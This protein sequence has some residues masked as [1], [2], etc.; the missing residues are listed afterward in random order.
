[1]ISIRV[2]GCR[3]I[4]IARGVWRIEY[5][6]TIGAYRIHRVWLEWPPVFETNYHMQN[7]VRLNLQWRR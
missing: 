5:E 4:R 1:M 7:L 2:L 6:Y 3:A